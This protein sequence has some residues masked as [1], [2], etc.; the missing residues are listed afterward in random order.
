MEGWS[1]NDRLFEFI[2]YFI[3]HFVIFIVDCR[4]AESHLLQEIFIF[5][6][7]LVCIKVIVK[8]EVVRL[9]QVIS[10]HNLNALD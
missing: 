9:K 1:H 6:L 4:D 7:L 5:E 8:Q 10:Y 3:D 2:M